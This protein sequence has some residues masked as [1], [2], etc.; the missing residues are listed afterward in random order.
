MS[1]RK[2]DTSTVDAAEF[3]ARK[4]KLAEGGIVF[5][6]VLSLC[7]YLGIRFAHDPEVDP[8]PVAAAIISTDLPPTVATASGGT[9]PARVVEPEISAATGEVPPLE[10]IM[11]EV[12][13]AVT[14]S[15]AEQAFYEGQYTLAADRFDTY[16][17]QHPENAW[18][19]YMRG[20]SLW[21]SGDDAAARGALEEA[22][23]VKPDHVKSLVNL[24]R[25]ELEL[26]EPEAALTLIQRAIGLA[27]EN[28]DARRV[29]G[30]VYHNLDR[31][32]DA[33]GAYLEV[34]HRQADDAWT[35]N[36][37]ALIWIEQEQFERALSPLARA[38]ELAPEAAV[39]RNNLGTA[40]ERTGHLEQACEQYALAGQFG[41]DHGEA[42]FFRLDAVTIAA[43][44]PTVDLTTVAAAWTAP[45][46]RTAPLAAGAVAAVT[47]EDA[48]DER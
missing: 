35:L 22:L 27:P 10:V 17:R 6:A 45:G 40:L 48:E 15:N 1:T 18:G 33:T 4:L 30:R 21:K 26:A 25:I 28:N 34:L 43:D 12:P 38:V 3:K 14:Y 13:L 5:V 36:N 19:H 31:G 7:V 2:R 46:A 16:C 23:R 11:P 8:T 39:I 44:D 37:L 32:D 9:E 24:A 47:L 42:S 29:L 41:S 20:L